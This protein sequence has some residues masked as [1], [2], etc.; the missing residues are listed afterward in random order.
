MKDTQT[1]NRRVGYLEPNLPSSLILPLVHS[2]TLIPVV[3]GLQPD[4]SLFCGILLFPFAILISVV[5]P[6]PGDNLEGILF[7]PLIS[8]ICGVQDT[9]MYIESCLSAE[10]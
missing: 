5:P 8:V 1:A 10:I 2:P 6:T 3:L 7:L 4:L 9:V